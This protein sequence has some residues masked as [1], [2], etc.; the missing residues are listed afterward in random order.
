MRAIKN[1]AFLAHQMQKKKKKKEE[2]EEKKAMR[3]ECSTNH[4]G[5][6]TNKINT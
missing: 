5:L 6:L 4:I 2:E 1:Q 3:L